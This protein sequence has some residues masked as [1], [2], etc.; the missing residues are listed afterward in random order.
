[1]SSTE[2]LLLEDPE[3]SKIMLTRIDDAAFT[4]ASE[5]APGS[6]AFRMFEDNRAKLRAFLKPLDG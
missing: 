6:N 2:G 5:L 4:V 3:G 1:M